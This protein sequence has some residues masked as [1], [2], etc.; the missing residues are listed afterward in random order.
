[1]SMVTVDSYSETNYDTENKLYAVHPSTIDGGSGTAQSFTP[2]ANYILKT[3]RY[4]LRKQGN[5][6]GNLRARLYAHSG[7]YGVSS[8][9]DEATVL[10]ESANVAMA[11][12]GAYGLVTFTFSGGYVMQAGVHYCIAVIIHDAT[13]LDTTN[14]VYWGFDISA[15]T[16]GGNDSVFFKPN[17]AAKWQDYAFDNCFYV[18]GDLP[19]SSGDGES[20]GMA[21]LQ[22]IV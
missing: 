18:D 4:Y 1:M 5:P 13:T 16:H 22:R 9:P 2:A 8:I 11:G 7:V 19:V 3:C 21:K 6:V 14:C 20:V 15:P 12:L 10:D 17:G